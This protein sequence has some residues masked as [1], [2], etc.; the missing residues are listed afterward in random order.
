MNSALN[1]A[2][3]SAIAAAIS[4]EHP[5]V[6]ADGP[7]AVMNGGD[8]AP[9]LPITQEAAINLNRRVK[10]VLWMRRGDVVCPGEWS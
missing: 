9:T 5:Q 7:G 10:L 4:C 2:R 6:V 3:R 1:C 8:A